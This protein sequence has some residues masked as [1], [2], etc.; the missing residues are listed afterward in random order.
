VWGA[1][2]F[3]RKLRQGCSGNACS[4]QGE[5]HA[6]AAQLRRAI[7]C[8][9]RRT[10]PWAH[11][12]SIGKAKAPEHNCAGL[13]VSVSALYCFLLASLLASRRASSIPPFPMPPH[14]LTSEEERH[15]QLHHILKRDAREVGLEGIHVWPRQPQGGLCGGHA[16]AGGGAHGCER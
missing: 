15:P 13:L 1:R 12:P 10:G 3:E 14:P 4:K 2:R 11:Q 7:C 9:Q 5:Q 16:S 6:G 8:M